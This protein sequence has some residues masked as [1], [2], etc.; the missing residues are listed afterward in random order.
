M[1][2]LSSIDRS[3]EKHRDPVSLFSSSKATNSQE[4]IDIYFRWLTAG[5]AAMIILIMTGIFFELLSNSWLSI[6]KFGLGFLWSQKWNAVTQEFGALPSIYGTIV[7]TV[8]AMLIAAPLALAIALFLVELAPPIIS[9]PVSVGIELLAAI[10]SI[11]YGMWGLFVFAPYMADH[12][13][14]FFIDWVQPILDT[15]GFGYLPLFEGYPM[16]IG[17]LTAGIILAMM[18][19]PFITA[20]TRDVLRMVP[21]VLKESAYGMGSTTWEVTRKVSI[22]YGIHGIVGAMFLGL[23]RAIGET[24]AITFVIGNSARLSASLLD[25]GQ[26][27]ASTLANE[28]AE[29]SE[30]IYMSALIEL[31]LVL[32]LITFIIQ[33]IS[34]YWLKRLS[35]NLEG[36]G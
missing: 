20:V 7:S 33:I 28:F 5:C 10:P 18:I 19:L 25:P 24:M 23:G 9:Y 27:I 14:P 6:Q 11:I 17:M 16:G 21:L 35:K 32:F 15:V 4:K 31:A 8:I 12:I 2:S 34:H 29:A 22:P 26:S 36:R 3:K 13:Q 1:T 30:P